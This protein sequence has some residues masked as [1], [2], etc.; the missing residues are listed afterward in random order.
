MVEAPDLA[1]NIMSVPANGI[2][3]CKT[4]GYLSS[5]DCNGGPGPIRASESAQQCNTVYNF[6]GNQDGALIS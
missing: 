6:Q 1:R 4:G 5:G 3:N 2:Q